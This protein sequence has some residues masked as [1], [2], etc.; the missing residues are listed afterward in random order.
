MNKD[1]KRYVTRCAENGDAIDTFNT[2]E[3]AKAAIAGY[4][5]EDIEDGSEENE[6]DA[7][8]FY[9]IYDIIK[10]EIL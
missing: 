10:E 4:V 1:T 9:E 3:E 8:A 2:I 7:A 6:Q 5:R